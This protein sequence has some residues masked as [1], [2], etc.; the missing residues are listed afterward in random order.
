MIQD[1]FA[2]AH[3]YFGINSGLAE[4]FAF[5]DREDVAVLPEGRYPIDGERVYAVV[6]NGPGR[7]R[8]DA[9]LEVHDCYIDVQ[10]ILSGTDAM[11]W[12]PRADCTA[13]ARR[14]DPR[15]DVAFF[16]DEPEIWLHTGPGR[17]AML[18]PWDAHMPMVSDGVVHKVILKVAM[19]AA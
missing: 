19:D 3:R 16:A 13:S 14:Y 9:L 2:Q 17:F 5:L 15:A 6:A 11:G 12:K 1:V 4:A 18:F 8:A 10:C 7:A